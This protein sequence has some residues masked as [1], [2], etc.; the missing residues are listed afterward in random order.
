MNMVRH[1]FNKNAKV[2]FLLI[3]ILAIAFRVQYLD[4]S[5]QRDEVSFIWPAKSIN[6]KGVPLFS[7]KYLFDNASMSKTFCRSPAYLFY[8]SEIM[9]FTDSESLIRLS[10]VT[11]SV[12]TVA[13]IFFVGEMLGGKKLGLLSSFLLAINRLHVEHSQIVDVDGSILTFLVLLA[14]FFLMKFWKSRK[15]KYLIYSILPI[16]IGLLFKEPIIL[17]FPALFIYSY[18]RK[19]LQKT[20]AVF[21]SSLAVFLFF[22]LL[23]S[24][25]YSTDFLD[26]SIRWVNSFVLHSAFSSQATGSLNYLQR[27]FQFVGISSWDLTLPLIILFIISLFYSFKAKRDE[28]RFLIYFSII[29]ILFC[30]GVLGVTRY[31]VPIIPIACLLA[32]TYVL[33]FKILNR[34]SIAVAFIIAAVCFSAFYLLKIRTDILFLNDFKSNLQLI[35]IPFIVPLIPLLF[36]FSRYRKLAILI[37]FGMYIGFNL[38]FAQESVNP[39]IT[40]DYGRVSID[41]ANFVKDSTSGPVVTHLDI[42]FYSGRPF[43]DIIATFLSPQYLKNLTDEVKPLYVVYRTNSLVIRPGVEDFLKSNCQKIG[44]ETSRGVEIFK[45]Y[46]C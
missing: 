41:A 7:E 25:L 6:E 30:S 44:G 26:C 14:V 2:I 16:S 9:H 45:A 28:Y 38:Y 22:M 13:L 31:F 35:A 5:F 4:K 39:L 10:I 36:Y 17:I 21:L 15:D 3:I 8:L 11:F 23:F 32:A 37:L 24:N 34:K 12:L 18:K 42:A 46:R 27:I 29:F 20:F 1:Y 40:P 19:E 33:D 43:Y